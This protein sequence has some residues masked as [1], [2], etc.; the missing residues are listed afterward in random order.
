MR[1]YPTRLDL[2]ISCYRF[3]FLLSWWRIYLIGEM[4]QHDIQPTHMPSTRPVT[5]KVKMK[6]VSL[7]F[8][9]S[10]CCNMLWQSAE[11]GQWNLRGFTALNNVNVKYQCGEF[12]DVSLCYDS[13]RQSLRFF[14]KK[15][16][17]P[18]THDNYYF[19]KES[20]LLFFLTN[21]HVFQYQ[22][23]IKHHL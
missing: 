2:N 4:R 12:F 7:E 1:D 13:D 3:F 23:I 16:A 20:K 9:G 14:F 5:K 19:W 15:N 8:I 11:T 10:R 21:L 6:K 22:I 17:F 18:H